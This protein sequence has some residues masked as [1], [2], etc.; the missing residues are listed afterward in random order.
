MEAFT[1]TNLDSVG[2]IYI[3]GDKLLRKINYSYQK[4]IWFLFESGFIEELIKQ[5][6]FV[7]SNLQKVSNTLFVEHK[8]LRPIIYPY[9]WTFNML[10][11]AAISF[12]KI[13]RLCLKFNIGLH[14]CHSS[15]FI[16][17]RGKMVYVDLGSFA[18]DKFKFPLREF[19]ESYVFPLELW[20]IGLEHTIKY[21]LIYKTTF[22]RMEYFLIMNPYL[23]NLDRKVLKNQYDQNYPTWVDLVSLDEL[24]ERIDKLQLNISTDWE[25]YNKEK[26]DKSGLFILTDR[27]KKIY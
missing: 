2:E 21:S 3:E 24:E 13:A 14:D 25:D 5:G 20:S 11:F 22:P 4:H 6:L 8:F 27:F 16:F 9:E 23:G 19:F 12:L 18:Y 10:K 26:Y 15:N 17:H 1:K 7:E